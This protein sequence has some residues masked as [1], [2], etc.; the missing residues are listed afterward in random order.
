MNEILFENGKIIGKPDLIRNMIK[1]CGEPD[2]MCELLT[3]YPEV[4][5]S[6]EWPLNEETKAVFK[7]YIC[8][9]AKFAD[10]FLPHFS[11]SF[12]YE[13]IE[14]VSRL[15]IELFKKNMGLMR[16]SRVLIILP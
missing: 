15:W 5:K 16:S 2:R 6:P 1:V 12:R 9:L 11:A 3:D 8:D 4:R 10:N 7:L 13:G 14:F